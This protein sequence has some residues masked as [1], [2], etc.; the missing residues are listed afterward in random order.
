M[1]IYTL[2]M[3]LFPAYSGKPDAYATHTLHDMLTGIKTTV[4]K[5]N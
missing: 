2:L 4:S 3:R 1:L 5:A